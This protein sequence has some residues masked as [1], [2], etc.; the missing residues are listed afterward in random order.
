M[1]ALE[2]LFLV[3]FWLWAISALLFLRTTILPRWPLSQAPDRW[4]LP[5]DTVRFHA[6]DGLSLEGWKIYG[7]P[8][9]PWIILCHGVGSNRADLLEIA[10][11]LHEASFNL[12]LFDFRGHGASAGRVTSFGWREQRDVEGALAFLGQQPEV[13]ARPYGVYGI[14]MGGSVAL[15]VAGRDERVG[16]VAVDSPYTNLAESIGIHLRLMYPFLPTI[17]FRWFILTVYRLRFGV[18]PSQVSPE[19]RG[20]GLQGRPLLLIQGAQDRRAPLEGA[21]KILANAAQPK[22]LW[23]V[24][25]ASHLESYGDNPPAYLSR[26][27]RFFQSS[28]K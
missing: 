19:E 6:T 16:A 26:L 13:P 15:M 28:L 7:E 1:I 24:Q 14:S 12:L 9:S 18:W 17:P 3:L 22:D 5:S 2:V 23:V 11:G 21:R 8:N 27:I 20:R 25:G 10:A 4:D